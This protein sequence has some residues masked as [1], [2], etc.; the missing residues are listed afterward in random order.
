LKVFSNFLRSSG[1]M[2]ELAL[3]D[4]SEPQKRGFTAT[5]PSLTLHARA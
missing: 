3:N 1:V 2:L 5:W 4:C